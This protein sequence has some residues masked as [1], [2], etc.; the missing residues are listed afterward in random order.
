MEYCFQVPLKIRV[1]YATTITKL[2][3]KCKK[4][5]D[6]SQSAILTLCDQALKCII[7]RLQY[8]YPFHN[9]LL[10][11]SDVLLLGINRFALNYALPS[12]LS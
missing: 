7:S 12:Q 4:T 5:F 11:K 6:T 3:A 1:T 8:H 2:S 9:Y 10:S